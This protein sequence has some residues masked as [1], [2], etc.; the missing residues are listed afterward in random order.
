[1]GIILNPLLEVVLILIKAYQWI[2]IVYVVLNLLVLFNVFGRGNQ[3]LDMVHDFLR[4]LIEPIL[5]KIK[6]ILPS[7]GV[8]DISLLVLFL[9]THFFEKMIQYI[10]LKYLA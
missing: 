9:L 6:N 5:K 1:M 4:R 8:F 10:L 3:F 2:L 7:F